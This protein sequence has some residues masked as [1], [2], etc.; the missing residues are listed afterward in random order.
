MSPIRSFDWILLRANESLQGD[1]EVELYDVF[2]VRFQECQNTEVPETGSKTVEVPARPL[3]EC[4]ELLA[5]DLLGSNSCQL[6]ECGRP[7]SLDLSGV[8]PR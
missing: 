7:C 3:L 8:V 1:L 4:V 2:N 5:L 6:W